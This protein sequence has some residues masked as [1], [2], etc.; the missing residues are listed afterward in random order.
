M[1]KYILHKL[2]GFLHSE[3]CFFQTSSRLHLCF[4]LHEELDNILWTD[5]I[6]ISIQS[7]LDLN[8]EQLFPK[9]QLQHTMYW[10]S[11]VGYVWIIAVIADGICSAWNCRNVKHFANIR[12]SR[13]ICLRIPM[14]RANGI[15]WYH[16][17]MRTSNLFSCLMV[18]PSCIV[19]SHSTFQRQSRDP[20][21]CMHKLQLAPVIPEHVQCCFL[22]IVSLEQELM[23]GALWNL[24]ILNLIQSRCRRFCHCCLWP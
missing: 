5:D 19:N 16:M 4:R 9:H 18:Y 20:G 12:V 13:H 7:C 24:I 3:P 10:C 14:R 2:C 11:D 8:Q 6:R 21:Q 17:R 22:K 23:D 1:F 15:I